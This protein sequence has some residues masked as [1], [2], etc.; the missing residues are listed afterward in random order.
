M[1]GFYAI[2]A[3]T[4]G[5]MSL[6][7]AARV[8]GQLLQSFLV[9]INGNKITSATKIFVPLVALETKLPS[10]GSDRAVSLG[11]SYPENEAGCR[12]MQTARNS[13]KGFWQSYRREI[14]CFERGSTGLLIA[15]T[16]SAITSGFGDLEHA[17]DL[18]FS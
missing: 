5:Q 17:L 1:E 7:D 16:V 12:A 9:F 4:R 6:P 10:D 15:G 13:M 11:L 14:M 8:Y 2:D 3:F 18:K